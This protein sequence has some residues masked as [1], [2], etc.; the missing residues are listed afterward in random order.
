VYAIWFSVVVILYFPCR[1]FNRY[2]MKHSQW[3]LRY[4]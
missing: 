4:V 2:K 3:W 1:W